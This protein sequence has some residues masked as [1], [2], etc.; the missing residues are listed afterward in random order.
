VRLLA[1]VFFLS[2]QFLQVLIA[3]FVLHVELAKRGHGLIYVGLVILGWTFVLCVACVGSNGFLLD[4]RNI[5]PGLQAN[6][7]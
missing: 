1:E 5:L 3:F 2:M 6:C 7:L 4:C